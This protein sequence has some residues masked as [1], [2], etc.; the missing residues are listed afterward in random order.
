MLCNFL[1]SCGEADIV[2]TV[3]ESDV[4]TVT[5]MG[6]AV[7]TV[8]RSS[9]ISLTANVGPISCNSSSATSRAMLQYRWSL[10]Q[11]S[12]QLLMPQSTSNQVNIFALPPL[13]LSLNSFYT[14]S[15]QT[16]NTI[17]FL[18]STASVRVYVQ[19]SP[20][21]IILAGGSQRSLPVG[22]NATL[23][24][25]AS[26]DPDQAVG[27]GSRNSLLLFFKW[28][29]VQVRPFV[30]QRCP[31]VTTGRSYQARVGVW[32]P[33]AAV[34]SAAYF[35]VT[36]SDGNKRVSSLSTTITC[37]AGAA[38]VIALHLSITS[39]ILAQGNP[40]VNVANKIVLS[41]LVTLG[42]LGTAVWSVDDPS[43]NLHTAALTP[44]TMSL[45]NGLNTVNFVLAPNSLSYSSTFTFTLWCST[46]AGL[47][48]SASIEISTNGVPLPG[49][50]TVTPRQGREL[51]QPFMLAASL[52]TDEDSPIT[53]A[54]GFLSPTSSSSFQSLQMRSSVASA[55]VALPAGGDAAN[56]TL[57]CVV[58]VFDALQA[59]NS[60]VS[61]VIVIPS[62]TSA[63]QLQ[64]YLNN[65]LSI[66]GSNYAV[67]NSLLSTVGAVLNTVT[68]ASAPNCSSLYRNPC[69]LTPNTCGPCLSAYYIGDGGDSNAAC[70]FV[71]QSSF[72]SSVVSYH[73]SPYSPAAL[74]ASTFPL[75]SVSTSKRRA[76]TAAI[77][78]KA[79]T[80]TESPRKEIIPVS[81]QAA[82]LFGSTCSSQAPKCPLWY[83]CVAQTCTRPP[84]TC[85][86]STHGSC[87]YSKVF[88][89]EFT[90][91]CHVGDSTCTATCQ[92]SVGYYGKDCSIDS[93]TFYTR[94]SV[95]SQLV[96]V[97]YNLTLVQSVSGF[98]AQSWLSNLATLTSFPDEL[99]AASIRQSTAICAKILSSVTQ[100]GLDYS[101]VAQIL[102]VIDSVASAT[103]V[104]YGSTHRRM[105]ATSTSS[106]SVSSSVAQILGTYGNIVL[107][108]M[109][110]G[111][112]DVVT[113]QSNFRL[114]AHSGLVPVQNLTV[115]LSTPLTL[116]EQYQSASGL[117]S[118]PAASPSTVNFHFYSKSSRYMKTA[119]ISMS[120]GL[121]GSSS[122][123]LSNPMLIL[124]NDSTS[125]LPTNYNI[126][127]AISNQFQSTSVKLPASAHTEICRRD[128][129]KVSTYSCPYYSS[130]SAYC[131]GTF[132]GQ[133]TVYCPSIE[134]TSSCESIQAV[135][136]WGSLSCSVTTRSNWSTGCLCRPLVAPISI[137]SYASTPTAFAGFSVAAAVD[138]L[139]AQASSNYETFTPT[140]S[141]TKTIDSI[142]A[143]AILLTIFGKFR[144]FI[145][146]AAALLV[147]CC[148]VY[149]WGIR[150]AQKFEQ[151]SG[152]NSV[153]KYACRWREWAEAF[154]SNTI[155]TSLRRGRKVLEW[156]AFGSEFSDLKVLIGKLDAQNRFLRL[157]LDMLNRP[158]P[159]AVEDLL[160]DRKSKKKGKNEVVVPS[161]EDTAKKLRRAIRESLRVSSSA[162]SKPQHTE[163]QPN[164][165][166]N[167]GSKSSPGSAKPG[168][169]NSKLLTPNAAEMTSDTRH[170]AGMAGALESINETTP[171]FSSSKI[172][173]TVAAENSKS[174]PSVDSIPSSVS[175][176][177][178]DTNE[179]SISPMSA[180]QQISIPS[181]HSD[182][183]VTIRLRSAILPLDSSMRSPDAAVDTDAPAPD[184]SHTAD[185]IALNIN[186]EADEVLMENSEKTLA[187][188]AA[189]EIAI[190]FLRR[191]ALH[192]STENA[193]LEKWLVVERTRNPL[194]AQPDRDLET[195]Q[196]YAAPL[197]DDFR[198]GAYKEI[199]GTTDK[200]KERKQRKD[201]DKQKGHKMGSK[202]A[203]N[204]RD[205]K[206][207]NKVEEKAK[208]G[209]EEMREASVS[210]KKENKKK[211]YPRYRRKVAGHGNND[212]NEYDG[213]DDVSHVGIVGELFTYD[214]VTIASKSDGFLSVN[215]M[216][217]TGTAS[218]FKKKAAGGSPA[219]RPTRRRWSFRR[220]HDDNISNE[221]AE[222]SDLSESEDGRSVIEESKRVDIAALAPTSWN[223]ALSD[224]VGGADAVFRAGPV[225]TP[226]PIV[227][228]S[229]MALY[230]RVAADSPWEDLLSS[231]DETCSSHSDAHTPVAQW[232]DLLS[233]D[234]EGSRSKRRHQ[235]KP[236]SEHEH[237]EDLLSS[238][239][240]G[241]EISER[242]PVS[243]WNAE[244]SSDDENESDSTRKESN[245]SLQVRIDAVRDEL[246]ILKTRKVVEGMRKDAHA[247]NSAPLVATESDRIPAGFASAPALH[248]QSQSQSQLQLQSQLQSHSELQSQSHSHAQSKLSLLKKKKSLMDQQRRHRQDDGQA[249]S[250]NLFAV[251]TTADATLPVD[252]DTLESRRIA[253]SGL[254][255]SVA[256]AGS[257]VTKTRRPEPTRGTFARHSFGRPAAFSYQDSESSSLHR[258]D[259]VAGSSGDADA[260]PF[261]STA[262]IPTDGRARSLELRTD[263]RKVGSNRSS[264][265]TATAA[266]EQ[267]PPLVAAVNPRPNFKVVAQSSA[268]RGAAVALR[269]PRKLVVK[270][271]SADENFSL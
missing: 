185:S 13:S 211:W 197:S 84:K 231:D 204:R 103:S 120:V 200:S 260:T 119:V 125:L 206:N 1:G 205:E 158:L 27:P 116:S 106:N 191:V 91:Q 136:T 100:L 127:T 224:D 233:S 126:S 123:W 113:V 96:S 9:G 111:Q 162:L 256:V 19:S 130:V 160:H 75:K 141:P 2:V 153:D 53:Y 187:P 246:I 44:S 47:Q 128:V 40:V 181:S 157:E 73:S 20:L 215:E 62:H 76:S 147:L 39:T 30:S 140:L 71:G 239:D 46:A 11:G 193:G 63:A 72:S 145:I 131:N 78:M 102:Q 137:R 92:C 209:K 28:E 35:T 59:N 32:A 219:K 257:E 177:S 41:A 104:A 203:K 24:A 168:N 143:A 159:P 77:G 66:G 270:N 138:V 90:T 107:A 227:S 259:L 118:V 255:L 221:D 149:Y 56:F 74:T 161:L 55:S 64:T 201:N 172:R 196:M 122:T 171:S 133:L 228:G 156:S 263:E 253:R 178:S 36:V 267:Q 266:A 250:T 271:S 212:F 95:R 94:Q 54:F 5:I 34:N 99:T 169:D 65:G 22:T 10:F 258:T 166:S 269:G 176:I 165:S 252:Q 173:L 170:G 142:S 112:D 192:L 152:L 248:P 29:C 249:S 184:L 69:G 105:Q 195:H 16:I 88:T 79:S 33:L 101:S 58:Q 21:V 115:T 230:G 144:Y 48:S 229:A 261:K 214:D 109:V 265:G 222:I 175:D 8:S 241:S 121:F 220:K 23:D 15:I 151:R 70:I 226:P 148:R 268:G 194:R 235:S 247:A 83:S 134:T 14:I 52:W 183:A 202:V 244:L 26:Y 238:D 117:E 139:A 182:T 135:A 225:P 234:D 18:T 207:K 86:C 208:I 67:T 164:R 4:P 45:Q 251:G 240:E 163:N 12:T 85:S 243:D 174:P 108:S 114:V 213:I 232:E 3:V 124:V 61:E 150:G 49:L 210:K 129:T 179:V 167:G 60:A 37:V 188:A 51:F 190:A 93:Q 6:P 180:T 82:N 89:R 68:C 237:W 80:L 43:V 245:P 31:T 132:E 81:A 17:T 236:S 198:E 50:F 186:D 216:Y 110:G 97:L 254:L 155:T 264:I 25:S 217:S 154:D 38:P 199:D 98:T 146:G 223:D 189:A 262:G 42:T 57:I 7:V 242:R 218:R 87:V